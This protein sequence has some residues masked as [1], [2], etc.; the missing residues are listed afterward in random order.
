MTEVPVDLFEDLGRRI[1]NL[2]SKMDLVLFSVPGK[3]DKELIEDVLTLQCFYLAVYREPSIILKSYIDRLAE[4]SEQTEEQKKK[5]KD[6][7]GYFTPTFI[8]EY[9]VEATI[10]PLVDKLFKGRKP[11]KPESKIKRLL[12]LRICDPAVGGGIFLVCAHDYLMSRILEIDPDHDIE[13]AAKKTA[14]CLFGV[15]INPDAV[16]G[17]KLALHLNIAKWSLKKQIQEFVNTA[18][19]SSTSTNDSSGNR[20]KPS[21]AQEP[22]QGNTSTRET[23]EQTEKRSIASNAEGASPSTSGTK[24]SDSARFSVHQES[25]LEIPKVL[26]IEPETNLKE[27]LTTKNT[28]SGLRTKPRNLARG[29]AWIGA[30]YFSPFYCQFA[31]AAQPNLNTY[32][33]VRL[34]KST[35][36][37]LLE[38]MTLLISFAA[39]KCSEQFAITGGQWTRSSLRN[40]WPTLSASQPKQ[41]T[42]S[43]ACFYW[44]SIRARFLIKS[45]ELAGETLSHFGSAWELKGAL[46]TSE[47]LT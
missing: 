12:R 13:S 47:V 15:D 27:W 45:D 5:R 6:L 30:T 35:S 43:R 46:K 42:N 41:N 32:S 16:E 31:R 23:M 28:G 18:N 29:L 4:G 14:K 44:D 25:G 3:K 19:Q 40:I 38:P 33:L 21:S 9:I 11:T 8:A 17:C 36:A 2:A 24:R 20:E 34:A 10:G 39:T 37:A 7:G 22:A 26:T 1:K